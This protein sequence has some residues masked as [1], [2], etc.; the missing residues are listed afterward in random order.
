MSAPDIKTSEQRLW[1]LIQSRL[2]PNADRVDIDRRIWELFGGD[3]AIMFTDLTGFS[4]GVSTFGI[5]H[6]L[7]VIL[8]KKRLLFP[9]IEAHGGLVIKVE[10]D[11]FLVM[12]KHPRAAIECAVEMQHTVQRYS[13]SRQPDEQVLL[14]IGIGYGEVLRIGDA[15]V[16]GREVNAASKLGED[17]AIT[18]EILV[19]DAALAAAGTIPGVDA[20]DLDLGVPGS[21]RNW[22]LRYPAL[23]M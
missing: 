2:E 8:E 20:T 10:A 23:A 18:H 15:D 17:T 5:I 21:E 19:T 14:C 9:L 7:Q 1:E 11:S 13:L 22:R 6:L 3:W 4:R 16:F 12:F